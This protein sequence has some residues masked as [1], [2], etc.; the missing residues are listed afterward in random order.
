M[1]KLS[2]LSRFYL[3]YQE[4]YNRPGTVANCRYTLEAISEFWGA[5]TEVCSLTAQDLTAFINYRRGKTRP[6]PHSLNNHLRVIRGLL[7]YGVNNGLLD[8][9]PFRVRMLKVARKKR[10]ETC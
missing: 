2:E 3:D 9:L 6:K 8:A 5:E 1:L 10:S 7:N 4:T